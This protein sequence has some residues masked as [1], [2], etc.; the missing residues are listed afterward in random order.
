MSAFSFGAPTSTLGTLPS[1]SPPLVLSHTVLP[2][3]WVTETVTSQ[4]FPGNIAPIS[5]EQQILT[6]SSWAL[7]LSPTPS[8]TPAVPQASSIER[9]AHLL[10]TT[11]VT[12]TST[13]IV[14]A[15]PTVSP[16]STSARPVSSIV[17]L[18]P[19]PP[20]TTQQ[21]WSAPAQMTELSTFNISAFSSGQ[22][23]L[24]IVQGI[25]ARASGSPVPPDY[26]H[27]AFEPVNRWDNASSV[28]QIRYPAKS[29]NP[30]HRP[31]GGAQ[32]Y[33]T[34]LDLTGAWNVTLEYS[35]F[36]PVDFEWVLAGKL[37]GLYGGHAGCS[38]GNDALDCFS[39]RLMWRQEGLGE[40]YLYAPKDAQ[41][42]D[43]CTDPQSVCDAVYGL[44]VGRGSF[45]WSRGKWTNVRQTVTLNTPGEQDGAFIL[46]V[47]GKRVLERHDIFYR[48]APK[49]PR[50]VKTHV[51]PTPTRVPTPTKSTKTHSGGLGGL[52]GPLLSDLL[53]RSHEATGTPLPAQAVFVEEGTG[54]APMYQ[55]QHEFAVH[56]VPT[57][58]ESL[59]MPVSV[60]GP[61]DGTSAAPVQDMMEIFPARV[62]IA[63]QKAQR[64]GHPVEFVGLF[65][66]TFFGGHDPRYATPKE[67]YVW[68]KDFA[69]SCNS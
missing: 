1:S 53:R 23:N 12:E 56:V 14:P 15:S 68:F 8:P 27:Y 62:P 7:L 31:V 55:S 10:I 29:I 60:V 52:L 13:V 39:T 18:P 35:I 34:P 63:L 54:M 58:P 49:K 64:P 65:F 6:P 5:K 22:N 59:E 45:T 42:N 40:L 16:S 67:Q 11:V 37:P 30:A 4:V 32:F 20:S 28:L 41:T 61:A 3:V 44:S 51:K 50:P 17:V 43:L 24:E 57:E 38:G 9:V 33:A 36:F 66:S 2:V 47:N 26:L 19:P 21:T 25:P 69:M 46:D 48:R